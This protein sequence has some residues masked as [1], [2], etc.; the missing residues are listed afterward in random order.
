MA[1][2]EQMNRHIASFR[3]DTINSY[4]TLRQAFPKMSD[5]EF[6]G[7][8][9]NMGVNDAAEIGYAARLRNVR[10]GR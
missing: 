5:N 3:P 8:L 1:L 10:D 7:L 2:T 4:N 9:L 6:I